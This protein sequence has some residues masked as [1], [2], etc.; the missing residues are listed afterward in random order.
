MGGWRPGHVDPRDLKMTVSATPLPPSASV[1]K[2]YQPPVRDQ[3]ELGSCT[4]NAGSEAAGFMIHCETTKPD[5]MFSRLDLYAI[6]RTVEGTP[7]SEDSGCQVRDVFKSMAKYGVCLE[8]EWPYDVS[9]FNRLPPRT[10]MTE[11]LKHRA[12]QYLACPSLAAIKACIVA[13]FPAIG[14]FSCFESLQSD[15][16][17]RTGDVPLP[18]ANEQQIG[19]H[20]I[21][22]DGYDDAAD[23]GAGGK[24]M[25]HF[26][27]SWSEAWGDG[28]CGRLP[29]A[30]VTRGLAS[31]FWTLRRI[32]TA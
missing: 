18:A 3:G 26:Q 23:D 28:G 6:T 22:F 25:L 31:D 12:V 9:V 32:T 10:L 4:A 27:N 14:G 20:C 17:S 16:T 2:I 29:Y 30:Y 7:L 19:G 21:Y 1:R 13:K 15:S 11:A 8:S 24:G 5:P